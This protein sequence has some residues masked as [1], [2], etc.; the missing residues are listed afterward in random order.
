MPANILRALQHSGNYVVGVFDGERMVGASAAWFGAPASRTMH[1]HITG[2]LPQYQ[3]RGI[4]RVLKQHQRD[5]AFAREAGHIPSSFD[6][7]I[8]RHSPRQEER[9][10][11]KEG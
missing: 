6:P 4:G 1:S 8:A 3:G 10:V 5:W 9:R 2:V 7:H 11:G